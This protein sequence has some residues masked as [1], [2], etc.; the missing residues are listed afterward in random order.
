MGIEKFF[1]TLKNSYG[2]KFI[3]KV[4]NKYPSRFLLIDFNSIIHNISQIITNS[5]KYLYHIYL[6]SLVKK[7]IYTIFD[8]NINN[9]ILNISTKNEFILENINFSKLSKYNINDIFFNIFI[10]ESILENLIIHKI[11]EYIDYLIDFFPQLEMIYIAIDGVPLY[12]KMCEQRARRYKGEIIEKAK[13]K[14]LDLYKNDLDIEANNEDIY[15]NHYNYELYCKFLN[16]DKNKISPATNFMTILE[17]YIL[18]YFNSYKIKIILDSYT[19]FGEGEKKIVFKIHELPQKSN[20]VIYSPDADV[21]ILMLLELNNLYIKIMRFDQQLNQLDIIDI[22]ELKNIIIKYMKYDNYNEEKKKEI[23]ID[24]CMIWT[25]FGND[26]LPKL[27]I[28]N[29]NKDLNFMLNSYKELNKN[30]FFFD[31]KYKIN[32]EILKNYLIILYN[33]IKNNKL[34]KINREKK[35]KIEKQIINDNAIKYY[36]HLF[37]INNLCNEYNPDININKKYIKI[38]EKNI[39]KYLSGFEW[40]VEYYLNHNINNKFFYYQFKIPPTILNIINYIN[41][42][43]SILPLI[44]TKLNK[45]IYNKKYFS[46]DL[47]L[48]LI[49]PKNIINIIHNKYLTNK[50]ISFNIYY[51]KLFN[52]QINIK[53]NNINILNIY[54]YLNCYNIM[55][56]SKCHLKNIKLIKGKKFL[57]LWNKYLIN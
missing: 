24:I 28:I 20:I 36:E 1:N 54:K 8:V 30:I 43:D 23:I 37:N 11:C 16:F 47:Q 29:T 35:W 25:L 17:E 4:N 40:I 55:W 18:N 3:E 42:I 50:F 45:S 7:N 6:I 13:D 10:K 49:S 21:I 52:N 12:A 19:N 34:Q 46:P 57:Q 41:K 32:W 44:K 9:N 27:D 31:K 53:F 51:N 22:N 39:I 14:L 48:M 33:K 56:L 26:F 38:S 5:L 15:Y 2:N